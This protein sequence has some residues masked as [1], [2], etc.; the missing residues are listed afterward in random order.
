MW[1]QLGCSPKAVFTVQLNCSL[2]LTLSAQ[3]ASIFSRETHAALESCFH[4]K[5]YLRMVSQSISWKC[6]Y[7]CRSPRWWAQPETTSSQTAEGSWRRVP[8]NAE[9]T[10][11]TAGV[12]YTCLDGFILPCYQIF[13]DKHW[14]QYPNRVH[15]HALLISN[16][17]NV[18]VFFHFKWSV[19]TYFS[20]PL[21]VGFVKIVSKASNEENRLSCYPFWEQLV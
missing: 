6:C 17:E 16:L 14:R 7:W 19:W 13:L 12:L 1:P 11:H 5:E 8:W 20:V 21:L 10:C 15:Q 2:S 3:T 4:H 9:Q 18:G